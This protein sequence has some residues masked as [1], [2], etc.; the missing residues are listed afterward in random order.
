[1]SDHY[2]VRTELQWEER[3]DA[4]LATNDATVNER[5]AAAAAT[6]RAVLNALSGNP[7][8]RLN[9]GRAWATNFLARL[10]GGNLTPNESRAFSIP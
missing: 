5:K 3:E 6:L 8:P 2:G 1:L 9:E 4:P 7:D 10:D